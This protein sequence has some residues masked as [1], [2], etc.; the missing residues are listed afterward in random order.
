MSRAL[1]PSQACEHF[2]GV[3]SQRRRR[4][5]RGRR[6]VVPHRPGRHAKLPASG[7]L[8]RLQ[9]AALRKGRVLGQFLGVE[10]GACRDA[11]RSEQLHGGVLVVPAGPLGDH[12][13][14]LGF[15]L[16]ARFGIGQ[17]RIVQQFLASQHAQQPLPMLGI[18][19]AGVD[20]DVVVGPAAL[21]RIDAA[22]RVAARDRLIAGALDGAATQGL[23]RECEA[24]VLQHGVLHGDLDALAFAGGLLLVERA[25]G[26]DGEQHAGA[27]VPQRRARA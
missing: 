16:L 6:P 23:R 26:A 20:V 9:N 24:D 2:A 12:G 8:H 18:G 3:L 25:Q 13:V 5:D 22:G 1:R 4:L 21:A 27:G 7:M 10:H 15:M 17:A 14:D 19:A 11:C